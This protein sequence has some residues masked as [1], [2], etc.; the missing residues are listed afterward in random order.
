EKEFDKADRA[1]DDEDRCNDSNNVNA[2]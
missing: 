2:Y 1:A